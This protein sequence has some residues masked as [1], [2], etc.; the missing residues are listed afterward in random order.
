[1]KMRHVKEKNNGQN[2]RETMDILGDTKK[3]RFCHGNLGWTFCIFFISPIPWPT[4]KSVFFNY[5][6]W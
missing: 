3:R 1:M 5:R 2:A 6:V 4:K